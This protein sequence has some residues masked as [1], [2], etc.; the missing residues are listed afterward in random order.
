[1]FVKTIYQNGYIIYR[2]YQYSFWIFVDGQISHPYVV[3][4]HLQKFVII[5]C[6][7]LNTRLFLNSSN[8]YGNNSCQLWQWY[9]TDLVKTLGGWTIK[10]IEYLPAVVEIV[11]RQK[12]INNFE[13]SKLRINLRTEQFSTETS[14]HFTF[15]YGKRITASSSAWEQNQIKKFT[16]D[17]NF[18]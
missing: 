5:F 7:I 18:F 4:V 2:S 15:L 10:T 6:C 16:L 11:F 3:F 1:M 9:T 13:R 14:R 12:S 17:C 8:N